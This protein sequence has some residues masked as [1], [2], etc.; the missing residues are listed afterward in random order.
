MAPSKHVVFDVVGTCVSYQAFFDGVEAQIGPAL[1]AAS[2]KPQ[3]FAYAWMEAA[4]LEYTFLSISTRYQPFSAVFHA[5]FYRVLWMSG[6]QKP[7]EFAT[8][9]QRDAM[10]Q[11]YSELEAREGLKECFELLRGAGFTVW[12]FTS[13]DVKRV[14]GY[15]ERSGI[16]MPLENFASCDV[17]GV[18]KPDP[19]AY[20]SIYKKF[21]VEDVKWFAAAHMWDV[22]AANKVG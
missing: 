16:E 21:E 10:L 8:D 19:K 3:L 2:I 12:C 15:F 11:T 17:E 1:L 13:G 22:S 20:E 6:I 4:E 7:R 9:A 14:K 5:I 18:A